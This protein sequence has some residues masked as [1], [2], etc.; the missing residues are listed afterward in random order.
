MLLRACLTTATPIYVL[1]RCIQRLSNFYSSNMNKIS[2]VVE[3]ICRIENNTGYIE[4]NNVKLSSNEVML[5]QLNDHIKSLVDNGMSDRAVFYS[6]VHEQIETCNTPIT[7]RRHPRESHTLAMTHNLHSSSSTRYEK[8]RNTMPCI[9]LPDV[10]TTFS[11]S[12]KNAIPLDLFFN[13]SKNSP[14]AHML[15]KIAFFL[16]N[17]HKNVLTNNEMKKNNVV[18]LHKCIY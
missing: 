8:I 10:R 11:M 4:Q 16:R 14:H 12:E 2:N 15:R 18:G 6:Y 5:K 7:K 1:L 17:K 9:M 13:S 3:N